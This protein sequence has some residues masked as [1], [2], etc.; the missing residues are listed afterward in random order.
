MGYITL[1]HSSSVVWQCLTKVVNNNAFSLVRKIGVIVTLCFP[2]LALPLSTIVHALVNCVV[3]F[4]A[5]LVFLLID[6]HYPITYQYLSVPLLLVKSDGMSRKTIP[7][8]GMVYCDVCISK[9]VRR[10]ANWFGW[11]PGRFLMW[12]SISSVMEAPLVARKDR[13]S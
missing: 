11:L 13:F 5:L 1:F 3:S 9:S 8:L 10:K 2:R 6:G 12:R 4:F 7:I